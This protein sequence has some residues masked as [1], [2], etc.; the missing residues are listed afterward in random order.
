M[1]HG[2]VC[3]A[4]QANA[5]DEH[6]ASLRMI[7]GRAVLVGRC[8]AQPAAMPS[9]SWSRLA[10]RLIVLLR[11]REL[12]LWGRVLSF[13]PE[14]EAGAERVAASVAIGLELVRAPGAPAVETAPEV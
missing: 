2:S 12:A 4:E 3:T 7:P 14:R 1:E 6:P 8:R 5:A 11:G 10:R 9:R 13:P